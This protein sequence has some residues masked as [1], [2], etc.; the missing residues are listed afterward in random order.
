MN[1]ADR[2]HMERL[3]RKALPPLHPAPQPSRDLWPDVLRG[4]GQHAVPVPWFDWALLGA[5]GVFVA[6]FP[7]T[8][9]LLLYYL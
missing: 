1:K 6:A 9:P 5:L 7:A 8:I 2:D 4:L 3:V